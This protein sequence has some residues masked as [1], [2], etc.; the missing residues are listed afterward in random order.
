MASKPFKLEADPPLGPIYFDTRTQTY[1]LQIPSGRF[2]N[3]PASDTKLHL[4]NVGML[5]HETGVN[6]I[7][8][9]DRA[10]IRAQI[11]RPIDFAGPAGH[12]SIMTTFFRQTST[13]S[14]V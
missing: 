4:Q 14:H 13:D 1:W 7:K 11:D 8:N 6:E 12:D 9:G 3:L 5:V 2:L 10:L